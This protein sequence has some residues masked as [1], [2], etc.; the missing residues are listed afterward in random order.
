MAE[1]KCIRC[2]WKNAEKW[3]KCANCGLER[4]SETEYHQ[5]KRAQDD[6]NNL[7]K[8]ANDQKMTLAPKW[9]YL[10]VYAWLDNKQGWMIQ[11]QNESI[12]YNRLNEVLDRLGREGWEMI[13]VTTSVGTEK[14]F[15]ITYTFTYTSGEQYYFKRPIVKSSDEEQIQ[16]NKIS[17]QLPPKLRK[18]LKL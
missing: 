5:L 11:N 3:E 16:I 7:L 13:G 2:G 9:E 1:W 10:V 6:I 14:P 15:L 12:P 17:E 4:L 8:Q 18:L